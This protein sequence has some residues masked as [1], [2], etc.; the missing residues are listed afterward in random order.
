MTKKHACSA[1]SYPHT[2]RFALAI[3]NYI[4]QETLTLT[5]E[6]ELTSHLSPCLVSLASSLFLPRPLPLSFPLAFPL[7]HC[8]SVLLPVVDKCYC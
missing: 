2:P 6:N 5:Y 7:P 8:P 4:C 3:L 1:R